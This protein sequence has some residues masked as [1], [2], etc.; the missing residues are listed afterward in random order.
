MYRDL[1]RYGIIFDAGSSVRRMSFLPASYSINAD[2]GTRL[3]I[4]RW[5]DSKIA[6]ERADKKQLQSLPTLETKGEWTKKTH[7]GK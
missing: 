6:R 3:H 4:Y 2:Q 5:L 7:P 1:G